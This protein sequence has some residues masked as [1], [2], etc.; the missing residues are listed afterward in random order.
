MDAPPELVS[1]VLPAVVS[2]EASIKPGHVSSAALGTERRSTG[3]I[4][5]TGGYLLTVDYV[6]LG[7]HHVGIGLPDGR[8]FQG[9]VAA[10][11]FTSGLAVIKIP[12]QELP[13]VRLGSSMD[14]VLGQPVFVVAATGAVERR[15]AEGYIAYLGEFDTH[16][17]YMLSKGIGLTLQSPG[18][19]GAPVF[20]LAGRVVGI[21]AF[22]LSEVT[23]ATVAIPVELYQLNRTELLEFGQVTSR[24]VRAWIGVHLQ[25][26]EGGV[27]VA[28]LISGGPAEAAGIKEGDVI[29]SVGFCTVESRRDFYEELWKKRA[30]EKV[31]LKILREERE[32]TLDVVTGSREEFY[33]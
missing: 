20:D 26:A 24:P 27:V 16:W 32:V 12:P 10:H 19:G 6:V 4:V 22:N 18:F 15:V 28:G 14:I 25:P 5:D 29:V 11:D 30:H 31:V 3:V 21:A 9:Q 1:K 33:K 8:R 2:I 17:E 13:A 23:R 7:A